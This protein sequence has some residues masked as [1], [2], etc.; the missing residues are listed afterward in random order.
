LREIILNDKKFVIDSR[1]ADEYNFKAEK[2]CM[3]NLAAFYAFKK[4]ELF[5]KKTT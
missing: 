5:P 4:N 1:V 2:Q 3:D